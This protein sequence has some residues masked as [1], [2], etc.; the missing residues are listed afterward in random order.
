MNPPLPRGR[1]PRDPLAVTQRY[2][3][4]TIQDLET[5]LQKYLDE[6]PALPEHCTCELTLWAGASFL[7]KLDRPAPNR[8]SDAGLLQPVVDALNV[9]QPSQPSQPGYSTLS[10]LDA[11]QPLNDP[12][13]TMRR[14]RAIAKVCVAAV[15]KT[16]GFRYSFHNSWKSG[17]DNAYR[18][19]YYCND[20]LL[21][22]DRVANGKSGSTGRPIEKLADLLLTA[23]R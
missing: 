18:F 11:L 14:Q 9:Q 1:A 6:P 7:V 19:S 20:S 3:C 15:Q 12:K 22:K 21:N 17:E 2:E 5:K 4:H 16:D 13:E 10:V 23:S 8:L